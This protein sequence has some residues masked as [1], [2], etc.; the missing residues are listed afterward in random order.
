MELYKSLLYFF[1][2]NEFN[3]IEIAVMNNIEKI[4]I[5]HNTSIKVNPFLINILSFLK[6]CLYCTLIFEFHISCSNAHGK[7]MHLSFSI[8]KFYTAGVCSNTP[9]IYFYPIVITYL[10]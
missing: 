9:I 6:Y 4:V 3:C 7:T 2:L 10:I 1:T 8:F 5:L